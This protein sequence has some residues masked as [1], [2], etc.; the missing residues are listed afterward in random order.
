MELTTTHSRSCELPERGYQVMCCVSSST[1]LD[2][3]CVWDGQWMHGRDPRVVDSVVHIMA[4]KEGKC[5]YA[6]L[7]FTYMVDGSDVAR[8]H[9]HPGQVGHRR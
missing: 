6:P 2:T 5:E 3:G 4:L 8:W 1:N 9:F 7:T